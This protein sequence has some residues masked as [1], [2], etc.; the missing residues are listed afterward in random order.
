MSVNVS[1]NS[2]DFLRHTFSVNCLKKW[3][4]TGVDVAAALPVLSAYLGHESISST[5]HYLRLTAEVFPYI[6]AILED[7]YGSIIPNIGGDEYESH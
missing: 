4:L 3:A 2:L 7:S 6:T 1:R 5:Q